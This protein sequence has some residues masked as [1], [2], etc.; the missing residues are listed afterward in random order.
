[1]HVKAAS[2]DESHKMRM[3]ML[4]QMAVQSKKRELKQKEI[5]KYTHS[6]SPPVWG[7]CAPC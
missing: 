5:Y 1:M 2:L 3:K 7:D 6:D 4:E